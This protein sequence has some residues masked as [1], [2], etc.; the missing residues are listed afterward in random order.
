[1][2]TL[3][4]IHALKWFEEN[5]RIVDYVLTV[6]PTAVLLSEQD[7]RSATLRLMHNDNFDSIMS[8]T[9]FAFPI[10]RAVFE[11]DEGFAEMFQPRHYSKRSQDL[12]EA[13]HDA[14]QFYV[15]RA[16]SIRRGDVLTN[17]K[18]GLHLLHRNNVVDIDNMEDIDIAKEKLQMYKKDFPKKDWVF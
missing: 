2:V 9:N 11:N 16:E 15:S 4:P 10:Q 18:V 6:Y 1:M 13:K 7:V 5:I 3:S 8:A 14:G 17:S 12:I